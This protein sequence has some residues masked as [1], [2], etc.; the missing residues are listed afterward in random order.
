[1]RPRTRRRSGTARRWFGWATGLLLLAAALVLLAPTLVMHWVRAS[2]QEE[3]FRT[4][5]EQLFGTRLQGRASLSPLR[6]TGDEVRVAEA[7]LQTADGWRADLGGLHLGLDWQGFREGEWRLVGGGADQLQLTRA[8]PGAPVPPPQPAAS[9]T[10]D[11]RVPGWLRRHLPD[12][13]RVDGFQIDR[14]GVQLAD[15]WSLRDARLR[16]APWRQG[17]SSAQ[18]VF[19]GGR[20]Q[21]D[22]RLPGHT[23]PLQLQ[24]RR[25]TTRLGSGDLQLQEASL[26]WLNGG[27][28]TVRG[29]LRPATGRWEA[30]AQVSGVPLRE[31]LTE[32]WRLRLSG[33]LDG[34]LV[35][36]GTGAAAPDWEGRL[37]L[38]EGV[39]TALPLLDR[40][41]AYTGV[42]R[43]KRLVLDTASAR[44]QGSGS[45]RR[46]EQVLVQSRGLLHLEGRLQLDG[47][48]LDGQ[49]L[50]GVTPETLRWIPGARQ[51]VFTHPHPTGP[52]GLLWTPLRVSGRLDAPQEDLSARL[53]AGAGKALL[54]TPGQVA[55]KGTELLLTPLLGEG[56]GSAAAQLPQEAL[57]LPAEAAGKAVE[58]GLKLLEGLGGS[59][60][61]K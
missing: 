49:F 55:G 24:L 17:E 23:T 2:F 7:G 38:H 19:E 20:L 12:R 50:L 40:L 60:L 25:A 43:F 22:L 18:A 51:H 16:L 3:A 1:M 35:L 59:L 26:H 28:L 58:G 13:V 10:A 48:Q 14:L 15:N 45:S 39:L 57:K 52:S 37:Q 34:D 11:S 6:W 21:T 61:G 32:D 54:E 41:A 29:H 53:A 33:R 44:V 8:Q 30:A 36:R 31:C 56:A 42:E 9:A 4:R 46:F 47:G 27:D 5:L